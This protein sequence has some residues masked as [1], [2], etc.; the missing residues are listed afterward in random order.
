MA[1][2]GKSCHLCPVLRPPVSE[3][4][5][6]MLSF[7]QSDKAGVLESKEERNQA[8]ERL[9]MVCLP[10]EN[11][12]YGFVYTQICICQRLLYS[13]CMNVAK[14]CRVDQGL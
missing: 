3:V 12:M 5:V 7:N 14:N 9:L 6:M 8:R 11:C 4:A 1:E 2:P 13:Q 10:T